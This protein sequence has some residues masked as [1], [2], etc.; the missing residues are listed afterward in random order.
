MIPSPTG[1]GAKAR[2]LCYVYLLK[3]RHDE[4]FYVGWTTN[5]LRRLVEHN[6]GMSRFT[7]RSLAWRLVGFEAYQNTEAAKLRE[8]F[9][10]SNPR[11]LRLFKKRLLNRSAIG[12]PRQMMG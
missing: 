4:I 11:M 9:L 7:R 12:R 10:K 3:S 2:R 8:R 1:G 5:L 6:H